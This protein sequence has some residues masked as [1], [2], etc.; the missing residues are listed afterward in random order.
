MPRN[1][2]EVQV[3]SRFGHGGTI[4]SGLSS[5]QTVWDSCFVV[6]NPQSNIGSLQTAPFAQTGLYQ[7]HQ[8]N[9]WKGQTQIKINGNYPL[10]WWGGQVSVV[11]QDLPGVPIQA[12][13]VIGNAA[14][15]PGL[16]RNLGQ[17]GA[18]AVC[19]GT[20]TVNLLTPFT[21]FEDRLRQ[22]DAR[23]AKNFSVGRVRYQAMLE[24][25]NLFN[26]NTVLTR[27]NSYTS[28]TGAWGKPTAI[29]LP[30]MFKIGAQIT[31]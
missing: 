15:A 31:F 30:R 25:Y 5:G 12:A 7:C 9:P 11:Y 29:L 28:S 14:I 2:F 22:L 20:A 10:P 17:C 21:E 24:A 18:A 13:A 1:G 19:N 4:A 27:S 3:S 16:G 26:S 23:F 6:D 8:T